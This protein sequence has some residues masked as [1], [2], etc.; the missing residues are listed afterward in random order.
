MCKARQ[1]IERIK[2]VKVFREMRAP[3]HN[4]CSLQK[5]TTQPEKGT[6][7]KG[8]T[9]LEAAAKQ[10]GMQSTAQHVKGGRALKQCTPDTMVLMG[11]GSSWMVKKTSC[12]CRRMNSRA[13]DV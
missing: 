9:A 8:E 1:D 10:N 11:F 2:S 4:L 12:G 7:L 6:T 5:R 13:E 3:A